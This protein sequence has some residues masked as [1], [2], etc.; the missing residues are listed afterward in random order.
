MSATSALEAFDE[1]QPHA[2]AWLSAMCGATSLGDY[3]AWFAARVERVVRGKVSITFCEA[4]HGDSVRVHPFLKPEARLDAAK[5]R[6]DALDVAQATGAKRLV[7]RL[8]E[9]ASK[10]VR[11]LV[12]GSGAGLCEAV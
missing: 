1:M 4:R 2:L 11:A 12:A 5:V 9:S 10:R 6:E 8:K 3:L 7:V